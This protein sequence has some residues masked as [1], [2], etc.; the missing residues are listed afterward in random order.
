MKAVKFLLIVLCALS[1]CALSLCALSLCALGA[2]EPSFSQDAS[3]GSTG[4]TDGAGDSARSSMTA[5]SSASSGNGEITAVFDNA[6][7]N[8]PVVWSGAEWKVTGDRHLKSTATLTAVFKDEA[9]QVLTPTPG[10]VAW[11]VEIA[12]N[13]AAP[14]WLKSSASLSGLTWEDTTASGWDSSWSADSAEGTPPTGD[15]AE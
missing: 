8:F 4:M 6:D 7:F 10:A 3:T 1:L 13:P 11:S 12:Q 5:Q 15:V 9:G 2:A 14:W